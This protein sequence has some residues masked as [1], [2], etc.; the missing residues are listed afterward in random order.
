MLTK[1]QQLKKEYEAS[2]YPDIDLLGFSSRGELIV[3]KTS[4]DAFETMT[5]QEKLNSIGYMEKSLGALREMVEQ[6]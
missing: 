2:K 6:D 1:W 4:G 5:K 3:L